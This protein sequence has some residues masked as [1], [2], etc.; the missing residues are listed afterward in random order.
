M[1]SENTV[2]TYRL[3]K[4]SNAVDRDWIPSSHGQKASLI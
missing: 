3:K 1:A 2:N 4:K